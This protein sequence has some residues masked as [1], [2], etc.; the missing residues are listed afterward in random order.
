MRLQVEQLEKEKK[1]LNERLR[2]AAKRIDHI[3]RAYRKDER[4]LLAQDYAEQQAADRDTFE[5]LQK[6]RIQNSLAAHTQ[7]LANKKRLGRMLDEFRGHRETL[8]GARLEEY[9]RRKASAEKKME[10]E[11]EK[12]RRAHAAQKEAERKELEEAEAAA[13]REEEERLRVEAGA[14]LFFFFFLHILPIVSDVRKTQNNVRQKKPRRNG[15]GKKKSA[16]PNNVDNVRSNAPLLPRKR[17]KRLSVSRMQRSV[18]GYVP[19]PRRRLQCLRVLMG[20]DRVWVVALL[21]LLHPC[22]HRVRRRRPCLRWVHPRLV[23]VVDGANAHSSEKNRPCL[24]LRHPPQPTPH[25]LTSKRT[26]RGSSQYQRSKPGGPNGSKISLERDETRSSFEDLFSFSFDCC[27]PFFF[28]FCMCVT[29]DACCFFFH[30]VLSLYA[31]MCSNVHLHRFVPFQ[32]HT[33]VERL[34]CFVSSTKGSL[35]ANVSIRLVRRA[36]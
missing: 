18:R 23:P 3:E 21:L 31:F 17:V 2:I 6:A 16:S 33:G 35:S 25:C 28:F 5:D 12:Q 34:L 11:K 36:R 22:V 8:L 15:S 4:P 29:N 24:L 19:K 1:D 20:G 9:Q 10:E 32:Y 7:A 30:H 14:S 13:R 26:R 27:S